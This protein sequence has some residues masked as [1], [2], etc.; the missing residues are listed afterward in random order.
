MQTDQR[1][2]W[3]KTRMQIW[4]SFRQERVELWQKH[5]FDKYLLKVYNNEKSHNR[6]IHCRPQGDHVCK[7]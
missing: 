1:R 6:K 7:T 3:T 5:I 4:N 2:M